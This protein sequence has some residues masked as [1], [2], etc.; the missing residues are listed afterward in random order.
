M[1]L[2]WRR[3]QKAPGRAPAPGRESR[4]VLRTILGLDLDLFVWPPFR[5]PP[6]ERQEPR[7]PVRKPFFRRKTSQR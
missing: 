6:E 7:L 1:S 5:N 3:E 2:N 4:R